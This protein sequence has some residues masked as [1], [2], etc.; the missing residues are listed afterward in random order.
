MVVGVFCDIDTV[1][2]GRFPLLVTCTVADGV[3]YAETT[4]RSGLAAAGSV[5]PL[6]VKFQDKVRQARIIDSIC[7]I[8]KIWWLGEMV[9]E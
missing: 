7:Q 9:D 4:N 5:V 3:S 2:R 8:R 1:D 6:C